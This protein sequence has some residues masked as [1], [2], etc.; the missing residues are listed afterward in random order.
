MNAP[1]EYPLFDTFARIDLRFEYGSGAWLTTKE[2]ERY[3][4]FT[5]GIAV[6]T[7]GHAH[8]YLIKALQKQ[9]SKIWHISN[10]FENPLQTKLAE[11]LCA[12]SFA[13]KVFFTNSGAE[14][15]ECAIKTARRYHHV[16]GNPKRFRIITFEG[17]FHGRT[18][19]TLAASSQEKYLEGFGPKVQGFD[20]VPF[21]NNETLLEAIT[22]ETAAI[23]IEPI[24]GEG[25][26]RL[27]PAK[28][29]QFLRR[30]CDE[31]A[32][33]LIFDE[34][35]C[36]IG[37]TGRF[38]ACEWANTTPDIVGIAKGIGGGF[39]LGACL[40]TAEAAKGMALGTH[41][42]T[43]GGNP[44]A[45]TIGNAVLDIV[46]EAGFLDHVS[47]MGNVL[48]QGLSIIIDHYP[49]IVSSIEGSG[50]LTGL[51]CVIPNTNVIAALQNEKLLTVSAG[52]NVVRILPPLNIKQKEI[53]DG[54]SRIEKAFERISRQNARNS[55]I[56]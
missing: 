3:L 11:R 10:L 44:L 45:M 42:S 6:N 20:Q 34:V 19:A 21:G 51:K 48:K 53:Q 4:D 8:P 43:F 13:D 49:D 56:K 54:L 25:G 31:K 35:Q 7:L 27:V 50:L 37:R 2:G 22:E 16:N 41:G 29:L 39:P 9:A 26:L 33:L 24:Q 38:F 18:L 23:L 17:A 30:T 47:I 40:A 15:M 32:L 28:T 5:S 12:A 14:A 36:G 52:G 46:L 1:K 55:I